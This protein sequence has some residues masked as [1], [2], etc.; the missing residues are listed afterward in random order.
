MKKKGD[1]WLE[2][3]IYRTHWH[4]FLVPI[5]D[6]QEF[7]KTI[8]YRTSLEWATATHY[9]Q[10]FTALLHFLRVTGNTIENVP[11]CPLLTSSDS[12]Q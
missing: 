11:E 4:K 10:G 8:F 9:L 12:M 2:V 5:F 7:S 6:C 1:G 3:R